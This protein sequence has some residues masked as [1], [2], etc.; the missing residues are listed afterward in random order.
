MSHRRFGVGVL[1]AG[2]MVLGSTT[3][4]AADPLVEVTSFP[5]GD[6]STFISSIAVTPDGS[7][8]FITDL[9]NSAVLAYDTATGTELASIPSVGTSPMDVAISGGL[10]Y[11]VDSSSADLLLIDLVSHAV[12]TVPIIVADPPSGAFSIAIGGGFGYILAASARSIVRF[13]LADPAATQFEIPLVDGPISASYPS[14][15]ATT[16]DGSSAYAI[17]YSAAVIWSIAGAA[18]ATPTVTAIEAPAPGAFGFLGD[19]AIGSNDHAYITNDIGG[20]PDDNIIDL[21]IGPDTLEFWPASDSDPS[22]LAVNAAAT[23][24]YTINCA[25]SGATMSEYAIGSLTPLPPNYSVGED[26]AAITVSSSGRIFVGTSDGVSVSSIMVF[27]APTP[28]APELANTGVAIDVGLWGGIAL[29]AVGGALLGHR[30]RL[31]RSRP[32]SSGVD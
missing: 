4:A 5:V 16:T 6:D 27:S 32:R 19:I 9:A 23:R 20:S 14:A 28:P 31:V 24:L 15:V 30:I 21:A 8:V 10:A 26:P 2:A 18:T 3:A 29:L 12:S 17:D 11:V 7:Q 13:E 1:I 22:F 25:C